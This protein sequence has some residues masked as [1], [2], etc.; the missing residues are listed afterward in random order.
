MI[1]G[2]PRHAVLALV[3]IV[4]LVGCSREKS[5]DKSNIIAATPSAITIKSSRLSEPIEAAQAHCATHGK[6]AVSRGGVPLG[7]PTI[8]VMWGFDCVKE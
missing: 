5:V 4:V 8:N 6:K 2:F 3:L 7:S 1:M